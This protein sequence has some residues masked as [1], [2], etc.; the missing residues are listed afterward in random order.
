MDSLVARW[1]E[2]DSLSRSDLD[3]IFQLNQPQILDL[4]V[5]NIQI[6]LILVIDYKIPALFAIVYFYSIIFFSI[7]DRLIFTQTKSPLNST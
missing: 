4:G 7:E 3:L 6:C 5:F 2:S 1:K